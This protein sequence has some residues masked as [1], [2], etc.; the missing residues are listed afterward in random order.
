M[1]MKVRQFNCCLNSPF[2]Q[3]SATSFVLWYFLRNETRHNQGHLM[4]RISS[5]WNE[6][7][8]L[9]YLTRIYSKFAWELIAQTEVYYNRPSFEKDLPIKRWTVMGTIWKYLLQNETK[10][11]GY[12][13]EKNLREVWLM[14]YDGPT[15]ERIWPKG[16]ETVLTIIWENL[17]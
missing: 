10:L 11:S 13:F 5:Q 16:N 3:S 17:T 8:F 4:R 7:L 6:L 14:Y 2:L 12:Q 1:T 15:F 9:L